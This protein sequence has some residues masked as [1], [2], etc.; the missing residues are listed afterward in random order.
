M[1]M[2][3]KVTLRLEMPLIRTLHRQATADKVP[4]SWIIR[5]IL[6]QHFEDKKP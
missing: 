2:T 4:V 6:R 5:R 3:G 1:A